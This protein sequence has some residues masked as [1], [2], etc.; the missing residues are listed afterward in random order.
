M[1]A[2]EKSTNEQPPA[3]REVD[4]AK[5]PGPRGNQDVDRRRVD[6]GRE[7]LERAGAN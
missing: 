5:N 2:N 6:L 4:P 7:D 1:R 3:T